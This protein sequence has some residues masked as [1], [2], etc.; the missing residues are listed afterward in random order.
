MGETGRRVRQ[1]LWRGGD[2]FAAFPARLYGRDEQGWHSEHPYLAE[3]IA[4]LRPAV[5]VEVGVWKGA[6]CIF[7]AERLRQLGLDAVVVAVDTWLGSVASWSSAELFGELCFAHGYPQLYYK[8]AANIVARR[9]QDYVVPLPLD[10]VNARHLVS[11]AGLHA[12]LIHIDAG[13][14]YDSVTSDL[15][16][17]WRVLHPGGVFIGDDYHQDGVHW[18]EVRRAIDD[19]L[20]RTPHQ[21]FRHHDAKCR[22]VKL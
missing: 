20:A 8:F 11:R 2:P 6:S 5:V 3:A 14:D 4:E 9:L 10:S 12:D 22:A 19:F 17:W 7:M 13:H 18:P 1:Q 15:V 21:G 16:Q